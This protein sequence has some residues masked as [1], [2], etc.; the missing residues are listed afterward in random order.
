MQL[1]E[2]ISKRDHVQGRE[3]ALVTLL[4]YGDYEC[5]NC[6]QTYPVIKEIQKCLGD[7]LRFVFRHF[8]LTA[9]RFYAQ[10]AAETTEAAST[11]G[12]F[13]EMHNYLFKHKPSLVLSNGSVLQ[14]AAYLGLDVDRF[15]REIAEHVYADRVRSD[16][17]SGINS[18]VNGTPTFF[19]NGFRYDVDWNMKSLL[20][21]IVAVRDSQLS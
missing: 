2:P 8:P 5:S 6:G 14:Y 9:I 18:G 10:Q 11:Q 16:I 21:A 19:I 1:T 7:Q 13:W 3:D 17:K 12:R 15:E 20:A 4:E